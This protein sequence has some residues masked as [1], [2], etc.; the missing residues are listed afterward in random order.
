MLIDIAQVAEQDYVIEFFLGCVSSSTEPAGP[1]R[2]QTLVK[3][4]TLQFCIVYFLVNAKN[5]S[6][7]V[8]GSIGPR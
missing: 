4:N 1:I 2:D 7:V 3:S 8:Q 6:T 5:G